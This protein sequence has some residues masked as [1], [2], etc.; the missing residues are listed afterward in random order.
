MIVMMMAK[1]AMIRPRTVQCLI[2]CWF[3]RVDDRLLF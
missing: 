1:A 3:E 2:G